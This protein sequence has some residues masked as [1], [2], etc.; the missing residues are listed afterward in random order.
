LRQD[1]ATE[2]A[3]PRRSRRSRLRR[4]AAILLLLTAAAYLSRSYSLPRLADWLTADENVAAADVVVVLGGGG[5][6]RLEHGARMFHQVG[7]RE[8]WC[9]GGET[10]DAIS[11]RTVVR[12][13]REFATLRGVPA[14]AIRILP[15]ASTWDDAHEISVAAASTGFKR[16][17]VVTSWYH[18]R[19]AM[20]SVAKV[21]EGT[22]V[23]VFFAATPASSFSRTD[24]WRTE[25]GRR[26]VAAEVSKTVY[27][28][29]KFGVPLW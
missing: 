14:D 1:S 4:I 19:R 22:D 5:A 6:E 7:A 28:A 17:L 23:Q 29:W 10:L 15:S 21:L 20:R 2:E 11:R 12:D 3:G 13:V 26:V 25:E 8:L 27:Y 9:T 24:W 16:I 18:G